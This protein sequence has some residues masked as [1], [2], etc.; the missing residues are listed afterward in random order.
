MSSKIKLSKNFSLREMTFS[1]TAIRKNISNDPTME[2]IVNLTNLCCN[3]LQP[4][5]DNFK[6]AVRINSGFRSVE[7]CKAVGSSAK[8]QHAKGE[9]ADFEIN[10]LSNLELASWC[11]RNLDFDQ[12]ILEFH[13]PT[14]GDPNSGWVHCSYKKDGSNRHIGLIINKKTKGRYLPWKPK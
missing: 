11:Y 9:A 2:E 3:I 4:V 8:S 6:K 14:G 13:D 7:L 5:R 12:I 10:G 1:D